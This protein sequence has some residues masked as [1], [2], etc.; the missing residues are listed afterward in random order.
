M[1]R[2]E[3]SFIHESE[4]VN[5]QST[6]EL[7]EKIKANQPSGKL[8]FIADNARYY[9]SNMV[10]EYLKRNKRVK[11]IFLPPYS[12]NLNLI[13]RLWKF[14]K[15]EVLYNRYYPS[16]CDFK[17]ATHD[18]F[19]SLQERKEDLIALLKDKFNFPH[20]KFSKPKFG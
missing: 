6:I 16:F 1:L 17:K 10:S 5:A 13:E 11:L 9:R 15:K 7:H 19:E 4:S 18:Y 2:L 12:P 8:F 20:E 3:M 14:Y